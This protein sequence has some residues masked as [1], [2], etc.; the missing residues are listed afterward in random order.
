[1]QQAAQ[2]SKTLRH[3]ALL[4]PQ[5]ASELQGAVPMRA[6]L[7]RAKQ[8]FHGNG[9]AVE[10]RHCP[11]ALSLALAGS[12]CRNH[13]SDSRRAT[14][15]VRHPSDERC[16]WTT[17]FA[18]QP[19]R[20]VASASR[21][22]VRTGLCDRGRAG[23]DCVIPLWQGPTVSFLLWQN[24]PRGVSETLALEGGMPFLCCCFRSV[25]GLFFW[26]RV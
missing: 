11:H 18:Q 15:A 20:S 23:A 7:C 5:C 2:A 13:Q 17:F 9:P 19:R 4:T 14:A 10:T 21:A 24:P 25:V 26:F 22:Q 1:M 3:A 8:A 6:C 16:F 12:R